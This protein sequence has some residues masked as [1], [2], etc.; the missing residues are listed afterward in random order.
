MK[1]FAALLAV[2][3]LTPIALFV[4]ACSASRQT[5]DVCMG[6]MSRCD[7]DSYERC[8]DDGN[9]WITLDDCATEGQICVLNEGC[10][11]CNPDVRGC[12]ANGEDIVV[13]R[14]D[15]SG[16]DTI[17]SCDPDMSQ[18]CE[19]GQCADACTVSAQTRSYSGCEY[20]AVD[21]DN[22]VV[23]GQGSAAAQQYAVVVSNPLEVP[24]DVTVEVNDAPPGMPLMTRVVATAHL[25]RVEGGGDL[26]VIDLPSRE[27]DGSSDPLLNDGPGT[28]LSS[29]AYHITSTA[30][31]I[32]YQ[33]NPLDNVNVFSNDASLLLPSTSLDT[34][35][36][37]LSW[38]QTL[39]VTN[40]PTTNGGINLRAFLTV[41]G[42]SDDTNVSVTLTAPTVPGGD[43]PA[44]KIG[45]TL[46]FHLGAFDVI[47][48][49]TGSFNADFT[50]SLVSAD[51]PVTVYTGS[52]ASD[53]PYYSSLAD[54]ECCA[55]HLEEQL[56]PT[57][58]LGTQFVAVKTPS[59][60]KYAI[61]A[62]YDVTLMTDEPE[63]WRILAVRDGTLVTTSLPPPYDHFALNAGQAA[64]F[65][66]PADFVVNATDAVSFGQYP[67]S[68]ETTGIPATV[69]GQRAPGG[70]PS[71]ILVPPVQ[72]W[73]SKYVFLVP[74]KYEF[75][76]ILMA[77]PSTSGILFDGVALADTS[78]RCE[79]VPAGTLEVN[80]TPDATDYV[81]V[82]CL[83]SD[84][85]ADD[86]GD[87]IYQNDGRHVVES[88]DGQPIGLILWGWDA[89]VSYGCPG[90]ADIRVINPG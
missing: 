29:N 72:Q 90:G 60:T 2:G 54:R 1:A 89:Y 4:A 45:D 55:D 5:G 48:L 14:H 6:G 58:S 65:F 36:L 21:L 8:A 73:R 46:V 42:M 56:F 31:I 49:E 82:R 68:Q 63:W 87:P 16:L 23:P 76:S 71:S 62:G 22:A 83:L 74:D 52:E 7:Q 70:D 41:V 66:T 44:G 40:D 9:S 27:V 57:S 33:Y 12:G 19:G 84:P 20:W 28:W 32:A 43:V 24:A 13:C 78:L 11:S 38:P 37:V 18:V 3:V 67:G 77:M 35:Y 15:G 25:A 47:N 86:Y 80:G 10:L 34:D 59:R 51:K 75:D 64:T 50:G 79:Y 69:N 81:A 39:A 53:V 26:A 85:R 17:A 88:V 61:A 30:P